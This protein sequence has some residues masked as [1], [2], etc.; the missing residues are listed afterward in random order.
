MKGSEC[1]LQGGES[2]GQRYAEADGRGP[3]HGVRGSSRPWDTAAIEAVQCLSA[4][5]I[6][7]LW[8]YMC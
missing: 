6:F 8:F 5:V 2:A 7:V 4:V 3:G 1:G